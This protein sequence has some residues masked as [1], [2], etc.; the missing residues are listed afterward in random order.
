M[1]RSYLRLERKKERKKEFGAV[2]ETFVLSDPQF[3]IN[4]MCYSLSGNSSF[5]NQIVKRETEL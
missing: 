5:H 3:L 4:L 2:L 1:I